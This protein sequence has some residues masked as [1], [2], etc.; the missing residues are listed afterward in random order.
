MD[1]MAEEIQ[2]EVEGIEWKEFIPWVGSCDFE[3]ICWFVVISCGLLILVYLL[4]DG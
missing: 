3:Y 2:C 4:V 1:D